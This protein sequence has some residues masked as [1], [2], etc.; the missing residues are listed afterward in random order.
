MPAIIT[1]HLFGEQSATLLPEGMVS[2]E[3]E[4]LAFLLGNQGPDP[5]FFRFFGTPKQIKNS[6]ALGHK[7]HEQQMYKAF[8]ALRDG[9]SHLPARDAQVG[10]AFA[11]GVLSH[12]AL[13]RAAHPFIYAQE[14]A[15]IGAN[16]ELRG[17]GSEVHAVIESEIDSW[18]LWQKRHSTVLDCPPARELVYTDRILQVAGALMSQVAWSVFGLEVTPD[19]YGAAVKSMGMLYNVIE[20][21]GSLGAHA[22]GNIERLVRSH[23]LIQAL[24]HQVVRS[25]ECAAA[26]LEHYDWVSPFTGEHTNMSFLDCFDKASQG[27]PELALAFTHGGDELK[28][29]LGGLN[30]SGAPVE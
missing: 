26:N 10:R 12:Y 16:A 23:S 25:N 29:A 21:A 22:T 14:H 6:M 1:H 18:M 3:E 27:W 9:V 15:I 7:M 5:F 11:L 24:S 30:Y 2:S 13:D 8:S 4:L 19:A 28:S 17:S 20:P